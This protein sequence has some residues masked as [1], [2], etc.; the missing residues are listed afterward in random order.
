MSNENGSHNLYDLYAYS[1]QVKS[2]SKLLSIYMRKTED[3]STKA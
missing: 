1:I 3:I 2:I